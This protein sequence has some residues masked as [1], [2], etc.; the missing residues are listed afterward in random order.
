MRDTTPTADDLR[1]RLR[2]IERRPYPAYRDLQGSWRFPDY[3][4]SIDH[5]QGDPFAAPSSLSLRIPAATAGFPRALLADP[6][7]PE[8]SR[9]SIALADHLLYAF[10]E[11]LAAHSH[12]TRGSGKSGLLACSC[13]GEEVLARSACAFDNKGNLTARFQV[14]FPAAG[15]T[16]LAG[17]LDR[18]LFD[19]LP[20]CV[21]ASLLCAAYPPAELRDVADLA[22]DQTSLR[23]Q[24]R[25]RGLIAFVADGAVLPRASGVSQRPLEGALPFRSPDED[26]VTFQLPHAGAV[27]GM[28][29]RPGV[30]VIVGGGYHGKS[31]LLD[32]LQRG[33][34]DHVS[35]DGREL[36][37]TDPTATKVRA[38]DG[39]AIWDADISP[40]VRNLP[41]GADTRHFTSANASGS[42]SQAA[43]IVEAVEAD[44][45]VLLMD[46]DTCATNLMVRD[47]LM[48][49]VVAAAD[50]PIVPYSSLMRGL[51]DACGV[52]T[53]LVAGSSG[54]FFASADHVIQMDRY[55][56]RDVTARVREVLASAGGT[57]TPGQKDG[58]GMKDAPGQKD[59]AGMKDAPGEKDSAGERDETGERDGEAESHTPGDKPAQPAGFP[60]LDFSTRRPHADLRV[61]DGPHGRPKLRTDGREGF[62]V[63]R[64]D[65]DLRAVEQLVDP[66]QTELLALLVVELSRRMDGRTPLR[67][68]VADLMAELDRGGFEAVCGRRIPGNLAMV[69]PQEVHAAVDRCRWVS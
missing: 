15:R 37:A 34:Y 27:S 65:V 53:I 7:R 31:T 18:I 33:V 41:S 25:E 38:E 17:E 64:E 69:R 23:A 56:P 10:H 61:L 6:A 49:Q 46:E 68:L 36:V 22:E 5:V 57:G 1:A 60:H 59:G 58:A 21:R 12:Q 54:A 4:L 35:G 42:T 29:I 30:T 3:V 9:N 39:R 66:E 26:R 19:I 13:P 62:S 2:A 28:G 14:G 11:E 24:M 44:A 50:E 32:A 45:R 16:V 52:A 48:A 8:T 43:G 51:Y 63:N 47:D 20:G 67:T 40:F 55:E